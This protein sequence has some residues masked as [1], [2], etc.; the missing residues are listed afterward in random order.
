MA[1]PTK[2]GGIHL[3]SGETVPADVVILGVGVAPETRYIKDESLLLKDRSLEVDDHFKI[4]G[5]QDAYA[6]GTCSP[7]NR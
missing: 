3:K 4:K 5:V 7:F 6:V 1:D 2:V